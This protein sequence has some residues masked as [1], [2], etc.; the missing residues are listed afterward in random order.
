MAES[1]PL[2]GT[3]TPPPAVDGSMKPPSGSVNS[4]TTR[5]KPALADKTLGPRVA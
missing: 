1:H 2:N 4:E 3:Q 5:S